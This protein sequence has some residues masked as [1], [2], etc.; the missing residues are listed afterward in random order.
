MT[1]RAYKYRAYPTKGQAEFLSQN[2]GCVRLLWNKLV[3]N[4]NSWSSTG[5][6]QIMSEKSLK[7]NPDFDFLNDVISYALQQKRIDFDETKK[8]YFNKKRKV[9]LGKMQFK[10]KSSKRDSF[11]IPGQALGFSACV[12]FDLGTIKLPKMSP[13]KIVIDRKFTGTLKSATVSR[14]PS[15][16]YFVSVLV[17]EDIEPKQNTGRSVGIDLGLT[18]LAILSNGIKFEN[19]RWFRENQTKLKK[20]QQHLSRKTKGSNRRKKQRIKVAKI[21]QKIA[22]QRSWFHHNL[23]SWL[24]SNFDVICTEDLAVKN[25]VRNHKLSKSISDAGWSSLISMISYKSNWYG[26]TFHQIDR[27]Y[28]SSKTCG[29][30][31]AKAEAM[32]LSIREWVCGSCGANHDRDINAAVNILNTGLSDLYSLTSAELADYRRREEVRPEVDLPKASSMKR[33]VRSL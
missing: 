15:G 2:F 29:C 17:E 20:A 30:C 33:L 19:P 32:D 8:Q 11:R 5:P 26:R 10:S 13:V 18:H 25:M 22:N 9:K 12:D 31:G 14:N 4:F 28:A 6:N 27:W 1:L 21:H 16:Q 3:A 7:D 24:V 23:S